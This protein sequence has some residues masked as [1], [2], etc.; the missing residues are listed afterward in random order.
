MQTLR[1]SLQTAQFVGDSTKSW[2]PRAQAGQ[3]RVGGLNYVLVSADR[4]ALQ[5]PW[6]AQSEC[7]DVAH[8]PDPVRWR[9]YLPRCGTSRC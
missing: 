7:A 6:G 4:S 9:G 3:V 1:Y 2:I 8:V 5:R